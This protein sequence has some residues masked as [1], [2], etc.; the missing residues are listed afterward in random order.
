MQGRCPAKG[1]HGGPFQRLAALNGVHPR[2]VGHVFFHDFTDARSRP[3]RIQPQRIAHAAAQRVF[4]ALPVQLQMTASKALR[5][6]A[7]EHQVG[8]GHGRQN[9]ATA[10]TGR[11]WLGPARVRADRDAR[12]GVNPP[13]R[14]TAGTN[15]HQLD[16][17]DTDRQTTAFEVTPGSP[18][19]K[20]TRPR[21]LTVADQAN[22]GG[23]A[24][25]VKRQNFIEAAFTRQVRRQNG[26]P[27]R[28][29]LNQ[30]DREPLGQSQGG[31]PAT[32]HH[33]QQGAH[34]ARLRHLLTQTTQVAG[35]QRAH[36]G[37]RHR[38]GKALV[39][40][41]FRTHFAGQADRDALT[42]LSLQNGP[43][44]LLM[45]WVRPGVNKANCHRLH[46]SRPH[47][48]G[49]GEHRG[50]VQGQQHRAIGGNALSHR[51]TQ[52]PGHQGW[53]H[54]DVD[55]VGV[56]ALLKTHL[57]HVA[58]TGRGQQGSAGALALDQRIGGQGGAVDEEADLR[59][60]D[61]RLRQQLQDAV[62]HCHFGLARRGQHFAA[63]TPGGRF[64]H[65]IG[66]G[67]ANVGGQAVGV[68][69][70]SVLHQITGPL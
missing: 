49:S 65:H 11:A 59:W 64:Q 24:A 33:Q 35:H 40:P 61:P 63:E 68:A 66:E 15:L 54:F 17:R 23:G 37:V 50:F 42:Q 47:L 36:I 60:A 21:R 58:K 62:H 57:Q 22:L 8:V 55:V 43:R 5:I 69:V 7:S 28:A 26:A 38:G 20:P 2:G 56:K 31:Q 6:Q 34:H 39:F 14:A 25:H 3:E 41:H 46:A 51:E 19:L 67:A 18:H 52:R 1:D 53:R 9:A 10:V 32:R 45:G 12:Q 48:T 70:V 13:D 27:R 4:S 16:H 44:L 29:R 30:P